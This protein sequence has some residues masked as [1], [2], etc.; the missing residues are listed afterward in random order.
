MAIDQK[1]LIAL[2]E[3][4]KAG[5]PIDEGQVREM[6]LRSWK[7]CR[8]L[9]QP[10]AAF[11]S[12]V[13]KADKQRLL[14][15]GRPIMDKLL[16]CISSAHSLIGLADCE[17]YILYVAGQ[18]KDLSELTVF[19]VNTN[20]NEAVAGTNGIGT[21]VIERKPLEIVGA[22]H[23]HPAA[24][25]WYCCAAPIFNADKFAGVLNISIRM[26]ELHKHTAG[27]V[28]TAA[29]AIS[30]QLRLRS[31]LNE[32]QATLEFFDDGVVIVDS[33]G[34]IRAMNHMAQTMLGI[35]DIPTGAHIADVGLNSPAFSALLASP[36]PVHDREVNVTL[37]NGVVQIGVSSSPIP[38]GGCLLQLRSIKRARDYATKVLHQGA[39]Y[40]F[41]DILGESSALNAAIFLAK[42]AAKSDVTTLV[43]G[44]S[45]TGK[46]LFAQ[47]IHNASKRKKGPFIPVNCGAIPRSLL[48]SELFGYEDGT[49]TGGQKN[50]K[51]GK[52][53]LADGGTIFLDEIGEMPLEAQTSLLRLLQE[54]VVVRVGGHRQRRIDIRVVAATNRD[55][56]EAV[57]QKAFRADLFYRLNVLSITIPPLRER[58]MDI[59]IIA[60]RM[61]KKFSAAVGRPDMAFSSEVLQVMLRYGW[62][63]N[64]RELENVVERAVNVSETGV[65]QLEDLPPGMIYHH[66]EQGVPVPLA[67][68]TRSLLKTQELESIVEMLK[69]THGNVRLASER[70]GVARSLLYRKLHK[71][72]LKPDMWRGPNA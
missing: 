18:K 8:K 3:R 19:N 65:I 1:E 4:F 57:R 26:P 25:D 46:E 47:S 9:P 37:P 70:L 14:D 42:Q 7:R 30:E 43:F 22:E 71:A 11:E 60:Q 56:V 36:V 49:F 54:N 64:V 51:P 45:G 63:G 12:E 53:E 16:S 41:D 10:P 52:F 31:L 20:A 72:G 59:S 15:C 34:H 50:G 44:E 58:T 27:L 5:L 39:I 28:E 2:R 23:Y 48:E 68:P 24:Q 29:Y 38:Q 62:P 17:G 61:L 6:I 66:A 32:Q 13:P 40:N 21:C 33:S 69:L 55:L 67:K 35:K